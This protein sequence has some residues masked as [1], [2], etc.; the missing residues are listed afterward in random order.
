M[1]A[2][3]IPID[4]IRGSRDKKKQKCLIL[5]SD[6]SNQS[7]IPGDRASCTCGRIVC[8]DGSVSCMYAAGIIIY[9]IKILTPG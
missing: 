8:Y 6:S 2:G 9:S 1:K 7:L 3:H 5:F 4:L